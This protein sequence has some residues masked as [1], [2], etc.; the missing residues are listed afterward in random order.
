M[1]KG[2]TKKPKHIMIGDRPIG[3]SHSPFIIAEIAQSHEGSLGLA[4]AFIDLAAECGVDAVKFQT[5]IAAEESTK[6]EAFRVPLSGQDPTRYEY[7]RRMECTPE[8]WQGLAH[9]AQQKSLI[10]LSSAFSVAAVKLLEALGMP[11]WKVGSGEFRS[12]NLFKAMV[13][14]GRPL[15]LS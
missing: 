2:M 11:A 14:T 4:H 15:L 3:E 12:E 13:M 1:K 5:H 8:Q 10:F 6:D 7:W 9:H